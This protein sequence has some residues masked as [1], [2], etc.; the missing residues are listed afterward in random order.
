MDKI[1]YRLPRDAIKTYM[2]CRVLK[3]RLAQL[4]RAPGLQPGGRGFKSP[5]VHHKNIKNNSDDQLKTT[6]NN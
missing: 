5:S 2:P 3:G 1:E 4:G 6:K